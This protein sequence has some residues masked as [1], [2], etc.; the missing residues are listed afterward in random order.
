MKYVNGEI[1]ASI[2]PHNGSCFKGIKIPL[3]NISGNLISVESIITFAGRSVG[4]AEIR[5]PKAEK[6]ND[7]NNIPKIMIKGK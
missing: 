2:F 7:A 6:Q 1:V 4:E 5:D 3:M